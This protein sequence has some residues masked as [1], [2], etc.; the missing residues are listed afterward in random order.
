MK[1]LWRKSLLVAVIHVMIVAS[2][3]AKLLIDRS[4]CPRVWARAA[5][6]DPNLPIRGRYVSLRLE[7][8][9]GPGLVLPSPTAVQP[10]GS[11]WNEPARSTPVVLSVRNQQLV[12]LPPFGSGALHA[13]A[14]QR[15]GRLVAVL[16]QPL[17]YFIPEHVADPSRRADGEE[18]WVE[19]T[20]PRR[21]APRPILLGLKKDG[22]LTPLE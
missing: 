8:V 15:E 12:A 2:L 10:V 4:T 7:A 17:A 14:F 1:P 11:T 5:P 19:V 9:V 16:D 22:H 21:G 18:L 13:H 3:G 6:V 20:L